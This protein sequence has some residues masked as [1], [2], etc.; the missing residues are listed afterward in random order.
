MPGGRGG[1]NVEGAVGGHTNVKLWL[2]RGLWGHRVRRVHLLGRGGGRGWA[3]RG[4]P[5]GGGERRGSGGRVGGDIVGVAIILY[6]L[7]VLDSLVGSVLGV[8]EGRGRG[9]PALGGRLGHRRRA[10]P[11]GWCGLSE[12]YR[13]PAPAAVCGG[14]GRGVDAVGGGGATPLVDHRANAVGEQL[15]R[16]LLVCVGARLRAFDLDLLI[17]NNVIAY[18]F[19]FIKIIIIGKGK[20]V[21]EQGSNS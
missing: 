11:V 13:F 18:P 6:G 5:I 9:A 8:V 2:G 14:G 10:A 21:I 15:R 3:R 20:K 17:L 1:V 12:I 16:L 7:G 4:A 19:V